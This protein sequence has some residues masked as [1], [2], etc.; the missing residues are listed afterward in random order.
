M[1]NFSLFISQLQTRLSQDLPAQAAH[2]R[3]ASSLRNLN[4]FAFKHTQAPRQSGVLAMLYP[5]NGEMYTALMKRA[6][7]GYAHSGQ[8]SFPGGGMEP[9]DSSLQHAALRETEEEFGIDRKLISI[10]GSLSELYIPVSNNIV[11]PTVGSLQKPPTFIPN[12]AEVAQIIEVPI[13]YLLDK[14]IVKQTIITL[15]NGLQIE[16]PYFDVFGHIVWGATAMMLSELLQ[17][18]EETLLIVN[19]K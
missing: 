19:Y 11:L 17:I 15:Q 1:D 13:N 2:K 4:N 7:H 5:Q 14:T 10:V 16:A 3:M 8:I 6:E 18:V 9:T 12:A